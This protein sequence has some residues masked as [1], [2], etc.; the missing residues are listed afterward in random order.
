MKAYMC[1]S[2]ISGEVVV[3]TDQIKPHQWQKYS[4]DIRS[5][6]CVCDV[7]GFTWG[8]WTVCRVRQHKG[9]SCTCI[10][11]HRVSFDLST[12]GKVDLSEVWKNSNKT[13]RKLAV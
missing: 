9:L 8:S 3:L 7:Q 11:S 13:E 4:K 10:R 6:R 5:G 2:P 1:Q 12:Q